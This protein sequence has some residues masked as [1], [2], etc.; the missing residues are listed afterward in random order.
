MATRAMIL[1]L[2]LALVTAAPG[3]TR[4]AGMPVDDD[5]AV[6]KRAVRVSASSA[7]S[8]SPPPVP[9]T[10]ARRSPE[11]FKVRV[12]DKGTKTPRVTINLPLGL[13]RA[14]GEDLPAEVGSGHLRIRDVLETL[15]SG[16]DLLLVEDGDALI[17][18]FVE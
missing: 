8:P 7:P 18:I 12:T 15:D 10:S 5:L 2:G 16:Q 6:V 13:V 9:R 17:R 4:P 3:S 14:L 11:W 1:A